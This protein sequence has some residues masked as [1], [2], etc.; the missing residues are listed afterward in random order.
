M[1]KEEKSCCGEDSSDSR[2]NPAKSAG[3][4]LLKRVRELK[5]RAVKEGN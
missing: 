2:V 5:E 1:A 4:E 3:K